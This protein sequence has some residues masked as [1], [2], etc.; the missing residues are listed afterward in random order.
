MSS[1][2]VAGWCKIA[3]IPARAKVKAQE[4]AS[5][6]ELKEKELQ[7]A[8]SH[9]LS[10]RRMLLLAGSCVLT[11]LLIIILWTTF[12]EF[13]KTKMRNRIAAKQ[14]DELLAQREELRKG[15]YTNKKYS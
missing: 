1:P 15:V 14:I 13:A 3:F 10:E 4:Y 2:N 11:V 6:F 7:L 8:K 9:A 12:C 5:K